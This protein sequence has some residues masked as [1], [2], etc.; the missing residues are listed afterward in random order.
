MPFGQDRHGGKTDV[1]SGVIMKVTV[2]IDSFK[3]CLTSSEAGEAAV[4]GIIRAVPKAEADVCPIADG[5]EG[6]MRA[7]TDAL[8]GRTEKISVTGP[9]GIPVSCEYGICG[10]TAVI[11]MAAAAGLPLVP[12]E[13]RD[14]MYT[15]T[16]GVGECISDAI[17]KGC[18]KFIIG[19]GGS[20][21]NDGGSGMLSSLGFSLTDKNGQPIRDGAVGLS[22]LVKIE[23]PSSS[24]LEEC[25]F[26]IACDVTNP[27]CG[28]N[29]CSRIFAPQKGARKEDIPEM[30]RLLSDYA[31]IASLNFP[32]DPELPGA[33]A[34]G[35]LG[36]AF[37]AFLSGKLEKG[38]R[39]V[40]EET[41]IEAKI[42]SSDIVITG[43]GRLD[44]QT[45]MGKTPVGV[46]SLAKKYGKPVIALA[47]SIGD[48]AEKCHEAGIDAY[49]PIQRGPT[50]LEDAMKKENAEKNIADT[51]EQIFRLIRLY[52]L[53][54]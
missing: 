23:R 33:G 6:T 47:G 8:G 46:A 51:C 17:G 9:I 7:I 10:E 4:R 53:Y 5:G 49:F 37:S 41:G 20:A 12:P 31:K 36:F 24:V 42:A 52:R 50:T 54:E 27:L 38:I 18:R 13:K 22:E 29:G 15:T 34:A 44:G 35:G 14:P 45:V 11:E 26:R 32:A 40:C 28:E 21:T 1:F 43:E 3:G 39:I 30:D 48:G 2:A 16:R 25:E 19:I